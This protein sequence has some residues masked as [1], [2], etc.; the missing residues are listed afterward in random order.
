[1]KSEVP[2]VLQHQV[3]VTEAAVRTVVRYNGYVGNNASHNLKQNNPCDEFSK[4][5]AQKPLESLKLWQ[6]LFCCQWEND[7]KQNENSTK[8]RD[9]NLTKL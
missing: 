3:R 5:R 2:L 4:R 6:V 9:G 8:W 1:M 7:K